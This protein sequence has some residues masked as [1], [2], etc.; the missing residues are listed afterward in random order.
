MI[1]T[2]EILYC[3]SK[4][5]Y[6]CFILK[7]KKIVIY[8][9]LCDITDLLQKYQ[10]FRSHKSFLVNLNEIKEFNTRKGLLVLSN[11]ALT[12]VSK[13]RM[14]SLEKFLENLQKMNS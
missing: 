3:Q 14:K 4:G 11:K 1:K 9:P 10:F 5:N 13:R 8:R 12:P 2:E 7:E 6:T